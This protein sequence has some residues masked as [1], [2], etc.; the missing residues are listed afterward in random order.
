MAL[1]YWWS[2]EM[3]GQLPKLVGQ[4]TSSILHLP[5][6]TPCW[7]LSHHQW[8]STDPTFQSAAHLNCLENYHLCRETRGSEIVLIHSVPA[9]WQ[10]CPRQKVPSESKCLLISALCY[11]F[12]RVVFGNI[13]CLEIAQNI[14]RNDLTLCLFK[15]SNKW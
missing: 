10:L 12:L 6:T 3:L 5:K 2:I 8:A 4:L 15:I 9:L 14:R 13:S 7:V 1:S 11:S